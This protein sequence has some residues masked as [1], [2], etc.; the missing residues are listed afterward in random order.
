MVDVPTMPVPIRLEVTSTEGRTTPLFLRIVLPVCGRGDARAQDQRY[1][2]EAE[3]TSHNKRS[4]VCVRAIGERI[5]E[6]QVRCEGRTEGPN[7]GTSCAE[8]RGRLSS[9]GLRTG[10]CRHRC[11][12]PL[13]MDTPSTGWV[14]VL[15]GLLA[16]GSLPCRS[17]LPS[18]PVAVLDL[19]LAANSCG[20]S[21]GLRQIRRLEF[22]VSVFP[23]SSPESPGEPA[24]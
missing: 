18:F 19:R 8:C 20:G 5:G 21:H 12:R 4:F 13:R 16:R 23:L 11:E 6:D 24:P 7:G 3:F 17:G 14:T 9:H 10:I 15:A 22:V 2:N 1:T